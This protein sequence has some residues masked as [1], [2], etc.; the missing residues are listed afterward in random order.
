[1]EQ[2]RDGLRLKSLTA[3][4]VFLMAALLLA[5]YTANI[6]AVEF[7]P[8]ESYWIV[9]SVRLDKLISGDF[10]S[11]LWTEDP[12]I[13]FEVRPIPSYLARIG[14]RLGNIPAGSLPTYWDWELSEEENAAHGA[15]PSGDVIWWSRF[16]MAVISAFS[17]L[18]TAI[19]LAKSH[20]RL[21]A[22]IFIIIS[23]NGYFLLT[24]RRSMS[25]ASILFFSV[26]A[27]VAS[28]KLLITA[29]DRD[30]KTSIRWAGVVGLFSGLAGQSKLTGLVC[31][32]IAMLGLILVIIPRPTQWL[33]I[34]KQRQVLII[35][36]VTTIATLGAFIISYPFY[37]SHT[38]DRIWETF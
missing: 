5:G 17:M 20:S 29:Q 10:D 19:L 35:I 9:S 27:L 2:I 23:F 31:A 15:M 16:P 33:T 30:L 38:V 21:A 28:Y 4:E 24:L 11:A 32:G 36:F 26:L 12:T 3:L 8:D 34:L 14:Q 1:M 13:A 6:A 22:Y 25:E 7:H 37:Y 18:L